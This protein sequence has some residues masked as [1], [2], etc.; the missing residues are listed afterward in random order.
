MPVLNGIPV[1]LPLALDSLLLANRIFRPRRGSFRA[2]AAIRSVIEDKDGLVHHRLW[3]VP[4][5]FD[6]T[7]AVECNMLLDRYE[8][9]QRRLVAALLR[10][11]DTFLDIGAYIG[12]YTAMAACYVG[13][14]GRVITIE[15]NPALH[16]RLQDMLDGSPY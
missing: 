5:T 7:Q 12:W 9:P 1:I 8:V 2:L 10:P 16:R 6:L 13:K 14:T 11:G 3:G 4:M 15:P